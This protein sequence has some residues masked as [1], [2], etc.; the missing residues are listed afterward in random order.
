MNAQILELKALH[1]KRNEAIR[2][3]KYAAIANKPAKE[4]PLLRW[5]AYYLARTGIVWVG[6]WLLFLHVAHS[7]SYTN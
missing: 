3:R 1:A 6:M 5:W 7:G 2:K 4:S